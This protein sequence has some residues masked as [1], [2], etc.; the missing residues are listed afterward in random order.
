LLCLLEHEPWEQRRRS[1]AWPSG[2]CFRLPSLHICCGG[3]MMP[4]MPKEMSFPLVSGATKTH[5]AVPGAVLASATIAVVVV[6]APPERASKLAAVFRQIV[7]G[8]PVLPPPPRTPLIPATRQFH[9][10]VYQMPVQQSWR[11]QT[12]RPA[13]SSLSNGKL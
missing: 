6:V 9:D 7:R 13:S 2:R 12:N 11:K 1:F 8:P 4:C 10:R 5:T 3:N